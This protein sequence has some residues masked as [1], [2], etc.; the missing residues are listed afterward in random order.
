MRTS[1][2]WQL[3]IAEATGVDLVRIRNIE[4]HIAAVGLIA[5]GGRGRHAPRLPAKQVAIL[6][7]AVLSASDRVSGKAIYAGLLARA[8]DP[9]IVDRVARIIAGEEAAVG[10]TASNVGGSWRW[11]FDGEGGDDRRGLVRQYH[12][13]AE[14]LAA[15]ARFHAK[16]AA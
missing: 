14:S 12:L 2:E 13:P 8:V 7:V 3:A 11:L 5:R 4:H 10:L 16:E 15:F 6:V 9:P 1:S